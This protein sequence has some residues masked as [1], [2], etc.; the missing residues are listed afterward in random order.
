MCASPLRAADSDNAPWSVTLVGL[1]P[2]ETAKGGG[3]SKRL[4]CELERREG[5]WVSALATATDQG[6]PIWTTAMMLVD[7]CGASVTDHRLTG[8]L[9]VRRVPDPWVPKDQKPRLAAVTLDA[10]VA[11]N[12]GAAAI[13]VEFAV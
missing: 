1:F 10:T 13:L 12:A 6:R 11:A 9:A 8:T 4:N 7:P 2:G 3:G 5:K